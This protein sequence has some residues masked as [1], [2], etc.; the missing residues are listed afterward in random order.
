ML[1]YS[2][3]IMSVDQPWVT[4]DGCSVEIHLVT[5]NSVSDSLKHSSFN[6]YTHV[7][8][9]KMFVSRFKGYPSMSGQES[10]HGVR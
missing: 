8:G 1:Q 7:I 3:L 10:Y 2:L 6:L 5:F 4:D 9:N